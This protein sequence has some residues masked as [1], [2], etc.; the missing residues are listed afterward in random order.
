MN[1]KVESELVYG[2]GRAYGVEFQVK[3]TKGKLT[4]WFNYTL[5][6]A[7]RQFDDI[8]NGQ[9]FSAR[10]D[11][12]H[13]LNLV[14]TYKINEKFVLSTSFVYYTGDA[15]TF[16]SAQYT[17]DNITVPYVGKRNGN[18]L[19]D[20]HRLDLGFTWYLKDRKRFEQSLNFSVYNVYARENAFSVRFTDSFEGNS[21]GQTQAV[22]TALFKL[23]PSVTY[24]FKIK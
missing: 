4:G 2:R 20:Y 14:L 7:L 15:V 22:Q 13:D 21:T 18:R 23:I 3:K 16:P 17:Y 10:Q 9:E 11:R 8:D 19:P 6:R 12:I 1:D 24:N 5:S